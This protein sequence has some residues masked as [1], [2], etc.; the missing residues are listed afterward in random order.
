M[1]SNIEP[2]LSIPNS[3]IAAALHI[4]QDRTNWP[5]LIHC[6]RYD[7]NTH[8]HSWYKHQTMQPYI[9]PYIHTRMNERKR[10]RK[11]ERERKGGWRVEWD[12][13][14]REANYLLGWEK[15]RGGNGGEACVGRIV[16]GSNEGPTIPTTTMT[17]TQTKKDTTN[18]DMTQDREKEPVIKPT[19]TFPPNLAFMEEVNYLP[20]LSFS[21]CLP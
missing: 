7:T 16:S 3:K 4:V 1:K 21:F 11:R 14:K 8:I 20:S 18:G 19:S 10:E 15:K 13:G 9:Q 6:A 17:E 12:E 5:I 2:F